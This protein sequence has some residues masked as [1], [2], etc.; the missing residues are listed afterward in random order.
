MRDSQIV[1]H[2]LEFQAGGQ[3]K[4]KRGFFFDVDFNGAAGV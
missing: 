2:S 1:Y 4:A 3:A